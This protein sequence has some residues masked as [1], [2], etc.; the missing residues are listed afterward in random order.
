M[1]ISLSKQTGRGGIPTYVAQTEF[2]DRHVPKKAGFNW[3][4]AGKSWETTDIKKAAKLRE[5][6]LGDEL[7]AE[8]AAVKIRSNTAA[9]MARAA[10]AVRLEA[11]AEILHKNAVA[12]KKA[13]AAAKRRAEWDR[14][15]AAYR[16][17]TAERQAAI[18]SSP[19]VIQGDGRGVSNALK[20]AGCLFDPTRACWV[21][22][23]EATLSKGQAVVDEYQANHPVIKLPRRDFGP[24]MAQSHVGQ[25]IDHEGRVFV[26]QRAWRDRWEDWDDN[27]YARLRP[28]QESEIARHKEAMA[29][30]KVQEERQ[31]AALRS[32]KALRGIFREIAEPENYQ[33]VCD[34]DRGFR[35]EGDVVN[36]GEGQTIYGGGEWFV[37]T[38]DKVWAVRGNGHDGDDWSYNNVQTGGAG[39][40]GYAVA[41]TDELVARIKAAVALE[42]AEGAS[43]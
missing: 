6:A 43:I 16:Q 23:D 21:A 32:K 42:N 2:V 31:A 9:A 3:N 26:V 15:T 40:I 37:I 24:W 1:S 34:D 7:K 29:I 5:H 20:A 10:E 39:A 30:L 22:L 41:K 38:E 13:E 36:I 35:L 25:T 18:K 19:H 27:H 11:E 8:L 12:K 28:A 4:P 33:R 17:A 14:K